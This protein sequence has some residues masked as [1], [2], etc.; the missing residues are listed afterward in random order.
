[1]KEPSK[2]FEGMTSEEIKKMLELE[3]EMSSRSYGPTEHFTTWFKGEGAGLSLEWLRYCANTELPRMNRFHAL[4]AYAER[5]GDREPM[6]RY[7]DGKHW[8]EAIRDHFPERI[9]PTLL[10]RYAN[11]FLEKARQSPEGESLTCN[12]YAAYSALSDAKGMSEVRKLVIKFGHLYTV[13]KC[14]L[15]LFED[16]EIQL[17]RAMLK[18]PRDVE[19]AGRFIHEHALKTLYRPYLEKRALRLG[20]D[21]WIEEGSKFGTIPTTKHLLVLLKKAC[22][23]QEKLR[24]FKALW[25]Y[26]PKWQAKVYETAEELRAM[27]LQNGDVDK[28]KTAGEICGKPLKAEEMVALYRSLQNN[29]EGSQKALELAATLIAKKNGGKGKAAA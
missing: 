24:I 16:E 18:R 14:N 7:L 6:F 23:A 3:Q 4:L 13:E 12:A 2:R 19:S 15:A 5:T 29:R 27:Y 25:A 1:M 8:I 9:T 26:D 20:Y 17:A 28:A 21:A 22:T 10:R 11:Y